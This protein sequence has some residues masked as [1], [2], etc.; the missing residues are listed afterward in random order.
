MITASVMKEL[1]AMIRFQTIKQKKTKHEVKNTS[2][3]CDVRIVV[4][5]IYNLFFK[6]ASRSQETE[7]MCS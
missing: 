3:G 4:K 5:D 1:K 6:I 2:H 7:K